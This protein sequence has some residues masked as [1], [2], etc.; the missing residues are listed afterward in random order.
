MNQKDESVLTLTI[1]YVQLKV[2]RGDWWGRSIS[3]YRRHLWQFASWLPRAIAESARKV[4]SQHVQGWIDEA[5]PSHSPGYR[6]I[7]LSALRG[8]FG[9]LVRDR[10]IP[11]DPTLDI[12]LPDAPI[13]MPR[14][15]TDDE[16]EALFQVARR[17]PRD[18]LC[19]SL[20]W[21]EMLRRH[22][23]SNLLIE[24]VDFRR[25][26]IGVRG[27]GYRGRV[28]RI[29][30]LS[31][32]TFHAL[33]GHLADDPASTGHVV[34]SRIHLGA[35]ISAA[36]VGDI[37]GAVIADAGLKRFPRDGRSS[38]AG[39]HTGAVQALEAG[40]AQP[41]LQRFLGHSTEAQ[42]RRYTTGAALDLGQVHELRA[43][44][45]KREGN[46]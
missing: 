4:R 31:D 2:R 8:F 20:C 6:R 15:F 32:P 42:L 3:V 5:G 30:P 46:Q 44:R 26:Q 14:A 25:R 41:I 21:N 34:R 13:P 9:W 18:L 45:E 39:R 29:V 19:V 28:S 24:D 7:R 1:T 35:G 12:E 27:K 17:D 10:R 11:R 16:V 40:V 36:R 38:H 37:I 22:E 43:K 23:V 33:E